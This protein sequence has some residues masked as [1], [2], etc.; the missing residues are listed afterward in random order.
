MNKITPARTPTAMPRMY[1]HFGCGRGEG[2][3][4]PGCSL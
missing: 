1:G 4:A 2:K 3:M